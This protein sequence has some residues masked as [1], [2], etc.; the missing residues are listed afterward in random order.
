MMLI[1]AATPDR[2]RY[3]AACLIL[4]VH[5]LAW[6]IWML[7][8]S[9]R[10][11]TAYVVAGNFGYSVYRRDTSPKGFWLGM[12]FYSMATLFSIAVICFSIVT[13]ARGGKT[14]AQSSTHQPQPVPAPVRGG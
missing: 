10:R 4:F 3:V 12:A 7:V 9:W 2:T 5:I 13:L 6:L 8:W 1:G 11:Q 14:Q